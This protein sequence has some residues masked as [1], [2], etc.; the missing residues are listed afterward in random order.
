V[1]LLHLDQRIQGGQHYCGYASD[2]DQR[3]KLHQAVHDA[4]YTRHAF[5]RGVGIQLVRVWLDAGKDVEYALKHTTGG[6]G[7]L[8]TRPINTT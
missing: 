8:P 3:V 1:Y 7:V 5:H 2:V 6:T 4:E